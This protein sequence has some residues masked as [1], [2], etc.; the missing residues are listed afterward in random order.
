MC[1]GKY[2]LC[3]KA[4]GSCNQSENNRINYE[5]NSDL[6]NLLHM[7]GHDFTWITE[8]ENRN[9]HDVLEWTIIVTILIILV[10]IKGNRYLRV[11]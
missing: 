4:S 2:V 3:L 11:L 8:V 9:T 5:F 6:H 7:R 1:T 10:S